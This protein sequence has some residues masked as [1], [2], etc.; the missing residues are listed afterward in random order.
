MT[1]SILV[2]GVAGFIGYH[3]ARQ[4]IE[5]GES[6]IGIDSINSYYDPK[7]KWDRLSEL[8]KLGGDFTFSRTDFTDCDELGAA[9]KAFDFDRIVH[10]GAQPGVRYSLENPRAYIEANVVGHLNIL[11]LARTR[12]ATHL[13]Y[14]SSSSVYGQNAKIP[15]SVND[16]VDHPVSLYAATK[17]SDELISETYSHL[18]R[19]PQ[20]ALRFFTVYGPWGRPDMAPWLFTE[21]ILKG[22]P[23]KLFN[24]GKM[25]R[26][27]TFVDDIVAGVIAALDHPPADNGEVKAGGSQSPHAIYNIGNSQTEELARFVEV[28][29]QACGRT[30]EKIMLPMQAGDVPVTYAEIDD[31]TRDLGYR[32]TTAID[33]GIPA[34]VDWYRDYKGV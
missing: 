20:T 2:T 28:I 1:A 33:V 8:E 30:A 14:A 10:L 4:L 23:I 5:R 9:M 24:H 31:I 6:V 16:R 34:F 25:R 12:A 17:K 26:D 19:I 22:E 13:V 15:F 32:P 29:E 21:A 11:E 27:F 3:V 7:L 18:Y